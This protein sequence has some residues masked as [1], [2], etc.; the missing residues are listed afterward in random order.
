MFA[1][2]RC[3]PPPGM[4]LLTYIFTVY[5]YDTRTVPLVIPNMEHGNWSAYPGKPSPLTDD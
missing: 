4:D 1:Y 2:L 3:K 5:M